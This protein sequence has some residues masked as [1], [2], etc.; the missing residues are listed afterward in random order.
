MVGGGAVAQGDPDSAAVTPAWRTTASDMTVGNVWAENATL[1]EIQAAKQ[2]VYNQIQPLRELA[3]VPIGGQYINEV[4]A[5]MSFSVHLLII[6]DRSPM[7][8]R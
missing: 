7:T 2:G 1:A 8:S 5:C 3:P 6:V 4:R